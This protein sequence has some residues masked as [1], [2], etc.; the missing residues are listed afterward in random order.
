MGKARDRLRD[1]IQDAVTARSSVEDEPDSTGEVDH[2]R[3]TD[4]LGVEVDAYLVGLSANDHAALQRVRKIVREVVPEATERLRYKIPTF[5][6]RQQPLV[7]YSAGDDGCRFFVMSRAVMEAYEHELAP[8]YLGP[9]ILR[10]SF[11]RPLPRKL[12]QKIVRVRVAE[13][14]AKSTP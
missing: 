14:R 4:L 5:M 10:L 2:E 3:S 9:G 1:S 13:I 12:I 11:A 8:F 6:Y 7:G